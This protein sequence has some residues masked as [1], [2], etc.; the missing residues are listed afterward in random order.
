MPG[1]NKPSDHAD[2]TVAST[3]NK[4]MDDYASQQQDPYIDEL[5]SRMKA[6]ATERLG[7][8]LRYF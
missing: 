3:E 8:R 5:D 6:I 2:N 4:E 1:L 7:E